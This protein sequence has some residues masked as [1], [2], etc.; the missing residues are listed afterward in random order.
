MQ[1]QQDEPSTLTPAQ[2]KEM[3][4]MDPNGDGIIDKKEARAIAR[5]T[6]ELRASNSRLWKIV[7]GVVALLFLSWLGNAGLMTAVVFLSKDLKVE[8]SSLKNMD[9]DS[10]STA[11]QKNVYE[12]TLRSNS[13]HEERSSNGTTNTSSVV[14]ADV[15]CSTVLA[16]I[17]SIEKG[18]D[19]SLVKMAV[20]EGK[21]WEPRASA[22][23]YHLHD[24]SFGIEQVYLD[25]QHDVSYDV[26]C[27][28]PKA[29]CENAPGTPCEAV[30]WEVFDGAFDGDI[31]SRRRRL[32]DFCAKYEIRKAK[33]SYELPKHCLRPRAPSPPPETFWVHNT[34]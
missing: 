16:A 10:V 26:T 15:T 13:S 11:N 18:N 5:S 12:V 4:R 6:A 17:S 21:F 32:A 29:D 22:A 27:E 9:G 7:F 3:R 23:F 34:G 19:G 33:Y 30:A 8:G 24:D 20:G 31:P 1:A 25:N 28:M 2:E 14:V